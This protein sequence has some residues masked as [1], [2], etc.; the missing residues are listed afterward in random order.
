MRI[1]V[2]TMPTDESRNSK[3]L[4]VWQT[5][6]RARGQG[7]AP[8][9]S[10]VF[11]WIPIILWEKTSI[12]SVYMYVY[13]EKWEN[14]ENLVDLNILPR[15]GPSCPNNSPIGLP[16]YPPRPPHRPTPVP[17]RPLLPH[18]LPHRQVDIRAARTAEQQQLTLAA[19]RP[20]YGRAAAAARRGA[21]RL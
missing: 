11:N 4:V 10:R 5:T 15:N 1:L 18:P 13:L 16:S 20:D 21:A 17:C 19:Q 3:L 2:P 9:N 8:L 7:R 12:Y 14:R 6:Y